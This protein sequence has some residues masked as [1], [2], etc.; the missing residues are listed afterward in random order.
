[1]LTKCG[2]ESKVFVLLS[3]IYLPGNKIFVYLDFFFFFIPKKMI[4][5]ILPG[6][7]SVLYS[8]LF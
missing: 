1:M 7:M 5:I 8:S 4:S 6:K 3:I 2:Q